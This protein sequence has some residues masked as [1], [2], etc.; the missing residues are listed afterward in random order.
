VV[1]KPILAVLATALAGILSKEI[2]DP[3]MINYLGTEY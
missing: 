2:H 3:A 1:E